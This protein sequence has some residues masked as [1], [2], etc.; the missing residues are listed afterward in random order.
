[1]INSHISNTG[2]TINNSNRYL[3]GNSFNSL[4]RVVLG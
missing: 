4:Y 2:M 1:V 3:T